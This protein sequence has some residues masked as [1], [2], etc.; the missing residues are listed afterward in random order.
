MNWRETLFARRTMGVRLGLAAVRRV[1]EQLGRPCADVPVVQIVGTNGKGSTC[2]FLRAALEADGKRV[3]VFTSPHLVR[4][5]ERIRIAGTLIS[6]EALAALLELDLR[7]QLRGR[8][9]DALRRVPQRDGGRAL[10]GQ[11]SVGLGLGRFQVREQLPVPRDG[12]GPL[13][14]QR[15]LRARPRPL[16]HVLKFLSGRRA[17]PGLDGA[18]GAGGCMR[19]GMGLSSVASKSALRPLDSVASRA[20]A[21]ARSARGS[22][23]SG[24]GGG[25][26]PGGGGTAGSGVAMVQPLCVIVCLEAKTS[27]KTSGNWRTRTL[28]G[29]SMGDAIRPGIS[30]TRFT[31][32]H[33]EVAK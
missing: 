32:Y 7:P 29:S 8:D 33:I 15:R 9:E 5:N 18:F 14:A 6:N 3:H 22:R 25:A 28:E 11:S 31:T 21:F 23:G 27:A 20:A 30:E 26:S 10:A 19:D 17:A 2:A 24:G 4:F 12:L 13:R 16:A 1:D